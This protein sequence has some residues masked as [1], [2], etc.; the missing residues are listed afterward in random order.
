MKE[1]IAISNNKGGVG[2]TTTAVN[3]ALGLSEH[4]YDAR[5][6]VIDLD[7]QQNAANTLGWTKLE[8]QKGMTTLYES[9]RGDGRV[10]KAYA[11]DYDN[12]W[13]VPA[14]QNI[15]NVEPHVREKMLPV[16]EIKRLLSQPLLWVDTFDPNFKNIQ[17]TLEQMQIDYVIIDCAPTLGL[18]T[19]NAWVA[20]DSVL[21]PLEE[22]KYCMDG[23]RNIIQNFNDVRTQ[24]NPQLRFR[25]ILRTL[26]QPRTRIA[27]SCDASMQEE[28]GDMLLRTAI[29]FSQAI[30]NSQFA[31]EAVVLDDK[32]SAPGKAYNAL[33]VELF[34]EDALAF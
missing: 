4:P 14:G 15:V 26:Y 3:M 19:M 11:S 21:V 32:Q 28:F 17:M 33:L 31:G 13:Y 2:K 34:G 29:P 22:S 10:M 16:G 24:V 27:K 18:L 23:M 30:K 9:L 25:G 12:V 8:G 1:I 5:V 6:L 20:A 7:S